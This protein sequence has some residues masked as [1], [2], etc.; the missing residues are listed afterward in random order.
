[1]S[2]K[3]PLNLSL[4]AGHM[5]ECF[6]AT[7]YGFFAVLL[8]PLFFPPSSPTNQLL[9]SY[10]VFA[11]GFVARP[12]GALV[13]GAW[14]DKWGRRGPLLASMVLVGVPTM[15]IAVLPTYETLGLASPLILLICRLVQGFF[16]GAEY[17]GVN[18]Y[19]YENVN[20][21]RSLAS[22]SSILLALGY[23]GAGLATALGGIFT[24]EIMPLWAWRIP[25]FVGGAAAFGVYFWRRSIPETVAFQQSG[26]EPQNLTFSFKKLVPHAGSMGI[27]F[28][29]AASNTVPFYLV[30]IYGNHLYQKIG[31]SASKIFFLN[32]ETILFY[33][34]AVLFFGKTAPRWGFEKQ[35]KMGL[36]GLGTL[37]LPVFCFLHYVPSMYSI[38]LFVLCI[39]IPNS[40]VAAAA[41]P[42]M[43]SFFPTTCRYSAVAIS[44][45]VGYIL[46]GFTP[47]IV[48]RLNAMLG[49]SLAPGFWLTG[50]S[51]LTWMVI[52]H[53]PHGVL[54]QEGPDAS[55]G[56]VIAKS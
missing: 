1:M 21:V 20:S 11:M 43:S 2:P 39:S 13:L 19:V 25:F 12:L 34:L 48:M 3:Q 29:V 35:L 50:L 4:A 54:T 41:M 5:I 24:L 42:Y 52:H 6:D 49:T 26:Q 16:Y 46:S 36:V 55:C 30:T 37:A 22:Q 47:H 23:V 10:A 27:G 14:G 15:M 8:A 38:Y 53:K 56:N 31:C 32:T 51:L 18:V 9:M 7:I 44:V 28:L 45:S 40:C 33:A 17:A